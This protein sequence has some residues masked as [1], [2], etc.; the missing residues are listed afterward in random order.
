MAWKLRSARSALLCVVVGALGVQ[1]WSLWMTAAPR[2]ASPRQAQ[3]EVVV[4]E[5]PKEKKE[6]TVAYAISVTKDGS[7]ID[8]AAVLAHSAIRVH[9]GPTS[10]Y[11]VALV[12]FVA[13][14]VTSIKQL[15]VC[16]YRVLVKEL[17]LKIDEIRGQYLRERIGTNGCCGAWE[18]LKL[19]SW[20]L[21]E[22]HR[23]VHS[24]E[25]SILRDFI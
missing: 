24:A 1:L 18:L 9:R 5:A 11:G 13:P 15:Q 6:L 20:T 21:T 3:A 2:Q 4:Q 12:A 14:E 25:I 19:Y 17:P 23:V 10:R 7:Y 16:G 22:Y 8:G